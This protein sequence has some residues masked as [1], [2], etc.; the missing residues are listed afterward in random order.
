MVFGL[1]PSLFGGRI[2]DMKIA[3][4]SGLGFQE[5]N[6]IVRRHGFMTFPQFIDNNWV[7]KKKADVPFLEKW[8]S[9]YGFGATQF[10][11]APDN[12]PVEAERLRIK[13]DVNWIY[14]L[15][16]RDE[17]ISKFEWVGM[18]HVEERRDYDLKTFLN[19]TKDKKRWYLGWGDSVPFIHLFL[20][21]GM[22]TTMLNYLGGK[23]GCLWVDGK[24]VESD[25]PP[26]EKI[27]FNII[28]FKHALLKYM[29]NGAKNQALTDFTTVE[30]KLR[31]S[32]K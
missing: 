13:Y 28:S 11:V 25:L 19:L 18:P 26:I 6:R 17:D 31:M 32:E 14:P 21:D 9:R 27:E 2:E 24:R 22:D 29:N 12:M 20:F 8:L 10:A 1:Y 16:N 5:Y 7:A 4:A 3:M 30:T 23:I 15:H